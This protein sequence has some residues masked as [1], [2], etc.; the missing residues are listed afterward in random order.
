MK[1]FTYFFA[2]VLLFMTSFNIQ[3]IADTTSIS[4]QIPAPGDVI[5]VEIS[6]GNY[7][8]APIR[9][10]FDSQ[11]DPIEFNYQVREAYDHHETDFRNL[12]NEVYTRLNVTN[13]ADHPVLLLEPDSYNSW[14]RVTYANIIMGESQAPWMSVMWHS[15]IATYGND[16]NDLAYAL[17]YNANANYSELT[18]IVGGWPYDFG[19]GKYFPY[20]E[21]EL[22]RRG[23]SLFWASTRCPYDARPYLLNNILLCGDQWDNITA[24]EI[25]HLE[26]RIDLQRLEYAHKAVVRGTSPRKFLIW[27]AGKKLCDDGI[28]LSWDLAFQQSHFQTNGAEYIRQWVF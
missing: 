26:E 15:M 7:G 19:Y 1:K 21:P 11:N 14:R 3:V 12:M 28:M 16:Y 6:N 17:V 13:R 20:Y 23:D 24:S 4:S 22:V 2:L 8:P 9:I 5:I 25:T 27:H 18:P 10:G